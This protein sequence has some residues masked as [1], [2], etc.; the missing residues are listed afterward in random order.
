M[1]MKEAIKILTDEEIFCEIVV[2][3]Q[4]SPINNTP[5]AD[6]VNR[7][8]RLIT[9]EEGTLEGGVGNEIIT[10]FVEEYMDLLE[11]NPIRIA[12]LDDAIPSSKEL[13]LNF[14]PSPQDIRDTVIKILNKS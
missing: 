6:S 9:I 7:S 2:L 5:I 1:V 12:A 11:S 4:I 3:S 13:E 8:K 14:L 10:C